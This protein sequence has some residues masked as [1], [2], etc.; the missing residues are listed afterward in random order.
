MARRTNTSSPTSHIL[1]DDAGSLIAIPSLFPPVSGVDSGLQVHANLGSA[2]IP[3]DVPNAGAPNGAF[4]QQAVISTA[5]L[6]AAV[7]ATRRAI[8]VLNLDATATVYLGNSNVTTAT[9]LAL[10]PGIS[11][12]LPWIG[13]C[14]GITASGTVNVTFVEIYD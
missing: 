5:T 2:V 11:I 9:G 8:L 6:I 7:R 14:Y 4:G 10:K 12:S 3:V 1:T 13:A